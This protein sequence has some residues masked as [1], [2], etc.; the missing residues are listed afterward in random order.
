MPGSVRDYAILYVG[1]PGR[2]GGGAASGG[3]VVLNAGAHTLDGPEH[4]APGDSTRLDASITAHGLLP[5]LSGVTTDILHG[6]GTWSTE[7]ANFLGWWVVTN[8]GLV[9]NGATDDTA[10]LQALITLATAGG[11]KS[12]TIYFPPGIYLIAGALQNVGAFNGQILLPTV[13]LTS[14]QI[15][16]AFVGAARPPFAL[17]GTAP[18][19]GGY[20]TLKS[21]LAGAAGTAAV[22]SGGNTGQNNV[23]VVVRNLI[24]DA[25][26]NP[27]F[28]FWNLSTTQGGQRDG[29]LITVNGVW[30]LTFTQPSNANAY[31]I[32]LPQTNNSD[33]SVEDAVMVI[34]FYTGILH[35]ELVN[36]EYIVSLC[37]VGVELPF[38]YH[39]GGFFRIVATSTPRGVKATGG[40]CYV[41]FW[42]DA[43]HAN[44]GAG[45][46]GPVNP[47]WAVIVYDVDDASNYIRGHCRWFGVKAGVGRDNS[48]TVNGA[49]NL[50]AEEIGA[51]PAGSPSGAAGGDLAGTFPNP[52]VAKLNGVAVTGTPS[53]GHVPTATSGT[54]ATWQAPA[55]TSATKYE[56]LTSGAPGAP[57]LVFTANGRVIMV[58]VAD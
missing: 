24:C 28:T 44:T 26:N 54:A 25:P 11:T 41:D 15:T 23:Q 37:M 39:P 1:G 35:G 2:A 5:K 30:S 36:A 33:L 56:P 3:N 47:A 22:I 53:V 8:H 34:G 29:L 49:A 18:S 51:L 46:G 7:A 21:T 4:L 55:V 52:T 48:F 31:G 14:P 16:I 10:A 40:A 32:K 50:R 43:E 13:A 17:H 38:M 6:N 12:C 20:S 58:P 42:Y 57:E 19:P 27:T 45:G 9:G